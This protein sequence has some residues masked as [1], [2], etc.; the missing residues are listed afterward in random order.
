MLDRARAG[1]EQAFRELSDLYRKELQLHCYRILGSLAD[2]EDMLQETLLAAWRHLPDAAGADSLRAWLYRIATNRCL[3]ALRAKRRRPPEPTPPFDPT[4]P[5]RRTEITW[6]EPYPDAMLPAIHETAPGPEDAYDARE[7]VQLAFIASLQRLPPRQC[8]IVVLRDVLGFSLAEVADM[9][10][11]TDTAVKGA[12]QRA[13]ATVKRDAPPDPGGLSATSAS[14]SER[15]LGRR[16]AEAFLDDDIDAVIALLTDSAWLAMPP[17]PHEYHGAAAITGFLRAY[18]SWRG[19]RG[20]RLVRTG[21]NTQ[22]AFGYY[23]ARPDEDTA[24]AS[25]I[26]VLTV[27]GDRIQGVTWF[28]DADL[29]PRFDLPQTVTFDLPEISWAPG[30]GA[31]RTIRRRRCRR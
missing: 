26:I 7:A 9:L 17:A 18:L 20:H 15:E 12:L 14:A 6:L 5:S 2:A 31:A 4:E 19:Q 27:V 28:L 21:A 30:A 3:N 24:D 13:R 22:P 11:T 1:D 25:G 29:H 23:I 16:F 10:G 8:A